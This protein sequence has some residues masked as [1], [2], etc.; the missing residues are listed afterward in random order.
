VHVVEIAG[1][2][3][4]VGP[5]PALA[6]ITRDRPKTFDPEGNLL[7]RSERAPA[8][9][10]DGRARGGLVAL[11]FVAVVLGIGT[12]LVVDDLRRPASVPAPVVPAAVVMPPPEVDVVEVRDA[13]DVEV[14]VAT[15][16]DPEVLALLDGESA[17]KVGKSLRSYIIK[18]FPEVG[19][20][21][22]VR[23]D[24]AILE[25]HRQGDK[26]RVGRVIEALLE[27]ARE[28]ELKRTARWAGELLPKLYGPQ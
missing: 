25:L 11:G 16:A 10:S 4:R 8:T 22:F 13:V 12:A 21:V 27:L 28:P 24:K 5:H 2:A 3:P 7:G 17:S 23:L 15:P 1:D 14:E 9:I 26:E 19:E 6:R 20:E 18:H